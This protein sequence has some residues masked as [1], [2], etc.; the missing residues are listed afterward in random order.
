MVAAS[1]AVAI[2]QRGSAIGLDGRGG[3]VSPTSVL[4]DSLMELAHPL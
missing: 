2:G 3:P 1:T 4:V